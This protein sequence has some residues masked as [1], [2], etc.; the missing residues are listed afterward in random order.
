MA[1]EDLW[2]AQDLRCFDSGAAEEPES[3]SVVPI[4]SEG[5][6]VERIPVEVWWVVNKV[7]SNSVVRATVKHRAKPVSVIERDGNALNDGLGAVQFRLAILGEKDSDFMAQRSQSTG[8]RAHNVSEATSLRIRDA[9][10]CHDCDLH[11]QAEPHRAPV[12]R[13][14]G[15]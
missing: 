4:I 3:L 6:S 13:A 1:V 14:M 15:C 10:G 8:K 5:S 2:C 9:F 11:G 7:K 12:M